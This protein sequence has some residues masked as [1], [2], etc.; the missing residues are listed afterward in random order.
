MKHTRRYWLLL[1]AVFLSLA[2]GPGVQAQASSQGEQNACSMDLQ[3]ALQRHVQCQADS[4]QTYLAQ[5]RVLTQ[6]SQ[7]LA[8]DLAQMTKE[9][10]DWK[11]K[12]AQTQDPEKKD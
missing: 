7:Q 3:M 8:H 11:A 9:R 1:V 6:Q 12:A 5:V 10:D 4:V 2:H